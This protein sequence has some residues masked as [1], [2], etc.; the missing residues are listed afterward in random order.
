MASAQQSAGKL[1][2]SEKLGLLVPYVKKRIIGQIKS[3]ALIIV[4]LICFQTI[5]LNIPVTDAATVALGIAV[6]VIG[7]AFFM[8]GLFLGLMP[9]GEVIG[10]KLPQKSKLPIILA[11]AFI[12]GM[13]T[14][15]AEPAIGA[16]KAAGIYL[17]AWDAPLL[18][19]LLNKHSIYLVCSVGVGVGIAVMFG[20]L[21]FVYRWSLKPFSYVLVIIL[22]VFSI[23]GLFQPNMR[24]LTGLAWD[25]GAVTT[26]PVTVPLILALGIGICRIV[27]SDSSDSAGLGVVALASL[28]PILAVLSLGAINLKS[29]PQPMEESGF[30]T[31]ENQP[32]ALNLFRDRNEMIGYTL[33]NASLGSQIAVFDES[34]EKMLEFMAK[35]KN[36]FKLRK[37]VFGSKDKEVIESWAAQKGS[38]EQQLAI[39]GHPKAVKR[40]VEKYS[41]LRNT[42]L[43][44]RDVLS[45]NFKAATQ[46]IIPLSILFFLVLF[47]ILR[48]KLP[49]PDEIILGLCLAIIGMGL[50]N[51]GIE[52]GLSKLGNSVGTNVPS[53][54]TK[55]KLTDQKRTIVK[56]DKSIVKKAI[57]PDGGTKKYFFVNIENDY[58]PIPFEESAYDEANN[59]YIYTPTKGPLFGGGKGILGF[60]VVL[61]FAFIMG[62][63]AT[64]AEPA[65][66][67]LGQTVEELTVGTFKKSLLMQSVATGVGMGM[68]LG[69]SKIIWNIP[70][71]YLLVPSYLLLL[72]ITKIS[73]EEFVNI[74]WDSAGVTTGP[75]TVPLVLVLGLGIG[76]QVNV[77]EGFGVLS[78]ASVCPILSVLSVGLY[79]KK[80]RRA[81]QEQGES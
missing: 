70:L 46:A 80:K 63:G 23:W 72:F 52:L 65:L 3:V 54:F 37:A 33:Q 24:F 39:F 32:K 10:I 16:L 69:V 60:L 45:R 58:V 71:V 48:D 78:M 61:A 28:F 30:F 25:C 38:E 12:L 55:I 4:Y 7:L 49:R 67:A 68:L 43:K 18:F 64:L 9:L 21:R 41:S 11:F 66:N 26:G 17:K 57:T 19:I 47:L 5:V 75:I 31:E 1:K 62:Y 53:L 8:E 34:K 27:S 73:T 20:M 77:V 76:N 44:A 42:P 22:S 59:Q 81:L 79:L 50:F 13:V 56:F 6:V 14:T 15:F 74:A 29:V 36:D 51:I 2:F 40:A 35:L